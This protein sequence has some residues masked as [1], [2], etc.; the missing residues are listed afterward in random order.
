MI[1]LP[2]SMGSSC[3]LSECCGP[4]R[5]CE[6]FNPL[7]CT[8][9]FSQSHLHSSRRRCRSEISRR[10]SVLQ[11]VIQQFSDGNEP[12]VLLGEPLHERLESGVQSPGVG[13]AGGEMRVHDAGPAL[14]LQAVLG[15]FGDALR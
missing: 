11:Q 10:P 3:S 9:I 4:V 7:P 6:R 8:R 1:F 2:L 15:R 5:N 13:E 14:L 12:A